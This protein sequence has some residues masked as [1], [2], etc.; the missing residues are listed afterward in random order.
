MLYI[1]H[2][3]LPLQILFI[4]TSDLMQVWTTEW[5]IKD[6]TMTVTVGGQQPDQTVTVDSNI[7][8]ASFVIQK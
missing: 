5:V 3:N 4:I 7:L 6:C 8:T 2:F 1:E